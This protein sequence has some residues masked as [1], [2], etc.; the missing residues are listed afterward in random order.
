MKSMKRISAGDHV[1]NVTFYIL[2]SVFVIICFYPIWYVI[3][4]SVS[5]PTYVNSG[6]LITLPKG[7]H[8]AAYKYAFD[9]RQLWI[10]YG[11]TILYTLFGTF[12]GLAVCI[13][14]GYA[15]SRRDLPFRGL[16][17]GIFVFT[18]Y[19]GGGLIPTYIVINTLHLVNTRL[20]LI[21][22]GSVSVY[23]IVLIRTFCQSSIPEELREAASLDGCSNTRF[24]F[25]IVL[26][27]SKA[28]LAVIALYIA[29]YH[30]NSY[31]NA[32]VYTTKSDIQPLQLYLRQLLLINTGAEDLGDADSL[33]EM[34]QM[35]SSIR[36]AVIVMS[37][38]PIMCL[39]PFL[40]KY[41]VQG[42]MIGSIKS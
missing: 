3:V 5:D 17:M 2:L 9:Q 15:L 21:I 19:F 22:M 23:N 39:Y 20:L 26:P 37:S 25:S 42:V 12:F 1:T 8:F 18:M 11:N 31:Y 41:F 33:K 32:L 24:F 16:I 28:I 10:G 7:L 6:A 27:L 36:Y 13:P 34:Q 35:I 30:W 40:Q 38:L 29:V 4:A 14:C